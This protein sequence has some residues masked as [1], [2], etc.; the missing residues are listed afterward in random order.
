MNIYMLNEVP[1]EML[2][3][4]G[5]KAKGL[6]LLSD[7]GLNIAKGFVSVDIDNE[8]DIQT[9][10]DFYENSGLECVAVRSS[11]LGEDGEDFS[12]AGQYATFLNISKKSG[13]K[14]GIADCIASLNS[15]TAKSYTSYFSSVR[16]EKMCVIV[17]EMIDADVSGV[18]FTSMADDGET[19]LVEAV[20]GLGE[21]LVAG[22]AESHSYS[23]NKNNLNAPN[24]ELLSANLLGRIAKEAKRASEELGYELDTEWAIKDGKLYWLQAR[25]I[26]VTEEIDD[27]EL[28]TPRIQEDHVLTT[29]NVG[30]MLPGAV[31]PLSLSTSVKSID[32]G[33]RKMIVKAGAAQDYEEMPEGTGIANVGNHLF[34]NITSASRIG[35]YVTGGTREGV[36]LS[37]CGRI[38]D[39]TPKP[40]VPKVGKLIKGNNARKYFSI[41][42]GAKK[43]CRRLGKLASNM[44]VELNEDPK[45]QI[46]EISRKLSLMDD[47]FWYH[48]IASA[49]SG[50]MS[51]ALFIIFMEEGYAPDEA[52]I[53]LAGLFEDI[54]GIESVDILRSLRAFAREL[55][56]ENKDVRDYDVDELAAYI[57]KCKPKSKML[58]NSFISRH[59]HRAIREAEMRSMS[60]HMDESSLASFVKSIIATGAK[61]QNKERV[62]DGYIEEVLKNYKGAMKFVIKYVIG[63]ARKGVVFREY[64]KSMSIK[65]LDKFKT[66]YRN[67]GQS[68]EEKEI[69]PDSDLIFFITHE[70]IMRL[71]QN[72]EA[73][74]IKR[75]IARRRILEE[76]KQFKF[77]EVCVGKPIP[78]EEKH[79]EVDGDMVLAGSSISRG[80]AT[81][82]ARIVK[83]IDDANKLE[84]GEIMV[85]SFTDIGW[86]PYYCVIDA[87]VTEVGSALS[88]G[89]VVARE[90]AL[91]LVSNIS[92]ATRKI[93]TGDTLRVD[94]NTGEVAIIG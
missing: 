64:T 23:I 52:K 47:G 29:C 12:S 72:G 70:E 28:D 6:K 55:I 91:P 46:D 85:A 15:E 60:W 54:D 79:I 25:P 31:T 68:L 38:L 63:Q 61:E 74:L 80:K 18:C 78:I 49:Y 84:K 32:F 81:G 67:L 41:L 20:K 36:E 9:A 4:V 8:L 14:K 26:T 53:K 65:V 59:G 76:Q 22:K 10:A 45:K 62:V 21:K 69:L 34:I 1:I 39:D 71:I 89:A 87:L 57:R 73:G 44:E 43:A 50:A 48:Y 19:M 88:H 90:Y 11:A 56:E 33:I 5:G 24:D 13:V 16:S 37:I 75:A 3:N 58:L 40:P 2:E 7:C 82:K 86:S 93:K 42:L 51:S 92:N 77:E 30:E 83:S 27:F 17:Q 66:A 94:A 35:D